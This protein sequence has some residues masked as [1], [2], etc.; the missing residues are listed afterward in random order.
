[1]LL[2][3]LHGTDE[4]AATRASLGAAAGRVH[5]VRGDAASPAWAAEV[6]ERAERVHG[7]VDIV[8]CNASPPIGSLPLAPASLG[9]L[10]EFV[11]RSLAMVSGPLAHLAPGVAERGGWL[12]A[13]SSSALQAP[14]PEWPH[15]V[16]A[17]AAV[18]GLAGW[19]AARHRQASVVV[20]RPP[21]L[22][23]DQTNTPMG[24]R[25]AISVERVA[26]T[27]VRRLCGP[28]V[29]GPAPELLDAFEDLPEPT[30]G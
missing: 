2:G 22:L 26:A 13:I 9:R 29:A 16:T 6:A 1:M 15:Y 19:A 7:G 18:E 12:V 20:V 4:A 17:K 5:L 27:V 8:V 11:R 30:A 28:A 14:P 10:D 3:H 23:T 25:G 24:R 21:K